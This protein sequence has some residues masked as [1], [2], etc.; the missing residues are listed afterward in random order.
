MKRAIVKK[1]II[2][3]NRDRFCG[4]DAKDGQFGPKAK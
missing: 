3:K 4:L 2:L 1:C